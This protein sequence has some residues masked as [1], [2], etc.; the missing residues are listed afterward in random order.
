MNIK[1]TNALRVV[2][3]PA[4]YGLWMDD[5]L[6]PTDSEMAMRINT[7]PAINKWQMCDKG[8]P[9]S[10]AFVITSSGTATP[11]IAAMTSE[12]TKYANDTSSIPYLN[13]NGLIVGYF[14]VSQVS[15]GFNLKR[16]SNSLMPPNTKKEAAKKLLRSWLE[17]AIN[18][19]ENS[20]FEIIKRDIDEF[21]VRKLFQP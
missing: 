21:R 3:A 4:S 12:E 10:F 5:V 13:R 6:T 8:N 19:E 17:D 7:T 18:P 16:L 9:G 1:T 14:D 2:T 11:N 20:S 15:T